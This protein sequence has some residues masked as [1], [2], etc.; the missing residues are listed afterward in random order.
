MT[1]HLISV[2]RSVLDSLK[3]PDDQLT[4][5]G[6]ASAIRNSGAHDLIP[7]SG[8]DAGEQARKASDWVAAALAPSDGAASSADP[9]ADQAAQL[10]AVA[11]IVRPDVWP[12]PFSAELATFGKVLGGACRLPD[13]D[14]VILVCSDT[15]PGLLA[16]V[17]NALA[18]TGG[19]FRRVRYQPDLDDDRPLV[20]LRDHVVLVRVPHLDARSAEDFREAMGFLGRLA[21]RLFTSGELGKAEPFD[22]YLSGGFKAAIPYLIGLAEAVRSVDRVSLRALGVEHLM[23]DEGT[24]PAEAFVLH[25]T[26]RDDPGS[27][28]LPLRF[29]DME[30]VRSELRDFNAAGHLPGT[31]SS[32]L[33]NGYAYEITKRKD[34]ET[35]T[36]TAFGAGLRAFLGAGPEGFNR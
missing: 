4:D 11:K 27:I 12:C 30:A 21:Q 17:W 18:L 19:D 8:G 23:P 14:I 16:G 3:R 26:A 24:Y 25:E 7:A 9:P 34:R 35:C 15:S 29:L 5:R 28:P 2:G 13:Q 20:P 33:L 31:P 22:F 36:L 10:T 1:V 32:R 6:L